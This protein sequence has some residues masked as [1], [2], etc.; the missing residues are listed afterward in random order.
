MDKMTKEEFIEFFRPVVE[1]DD[2]PL[3]KVVGELP[4]KIRLIG[5]SHLRLLEDK[6]KKIDEWFWNFVTCSFA[7]SNVALSAKRTVRRYWVEHE[8]WDEWYTWYEKSLAIHL[9][10]QVAS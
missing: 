4:S 5:S 7:M 10:R 1:F 8:D 6:A 3:P 9:T 2:T